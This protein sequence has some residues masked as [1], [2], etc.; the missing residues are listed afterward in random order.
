MLLARPAFPATL[1]G[2]GRSG[3]FLY[4]MACFTLALDANPLW[5]GDESLDAVREDQ[6]RLQPTPSL[7]P[8][9]KINMLGNRRDPKV[10]WTGHWMFTLGLMLFWVSWLLAAWERGPRVYAQPLLP[11]EPVPAPKPPRILFT[12]K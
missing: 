5:A 12:L 2:A 9:R 1:E 6:V 4:N 11:D 7:L 8:D 10:D 3:E